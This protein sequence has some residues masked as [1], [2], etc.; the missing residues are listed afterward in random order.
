MCNVIRVHVCPP[1][2]HAAN[3]VSTKR[4]KRAVSCRASSRASESRRAP[5]RSLSPAAQ[6]RR[7][8]TREP[9]SSRAPPRHIPTTRRQV[10]RRPSSNRAARDTCPRGLIS[11]RRALVVPKRACH[12]P[13]SRRFSASIKRREAE[14]DLDRPGID[15]IS[16]RS[17]QSGTALVL[18]LPTRRLNV[19][20]IVCYKEDLYTSINRHDLNRPGTVPV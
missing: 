9:A 14:T 20:L 17:F 6:A 7:A 2:R 18:L 13:E 15:P 10:I 1:R 19:V 5:A 12:S 4:G 16:D 11:R 3:R 8:R